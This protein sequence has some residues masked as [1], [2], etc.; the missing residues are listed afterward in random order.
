MSLRS[1]TAPA[2]HPT[3]YH[4]RPTSRGCWVIYP[5]HKVFQRSMAMGP[6]SAALAGSQRPTSL[7]ACP[8]LHLY[9]WYC[10][11][12]RAMLNTGS[13]GRIQASNHNAISPAG[14]WGY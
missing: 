9:P 10:S 1:A 3:V 7:P 5:P 8:E 14:R 4:A 13:G 11:W 12:L 6:A 2:M